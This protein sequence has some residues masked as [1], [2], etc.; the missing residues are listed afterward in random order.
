MQL[1]F[2]RWVAEAVSFRWGVVGASWKRSIRDEVRLLFSDSPSTG[3]QEGL[4]LH[5][6]G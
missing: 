2:G 1:V 4:V 6:L 5:G 3:E